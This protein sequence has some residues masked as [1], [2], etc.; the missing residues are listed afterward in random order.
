[1]GNEQKKAIETLSRQMRRWIVE[2]TTKAQSGHLTSSLS[3]VELMSVLF[4]SQEKLFRYDVKNVEHPGNDRLIFSKGHASP[5]FY[6]LWAMAGVID[7]KELMTFRSFESR[8]EGHPTRRFPYTEVPT[9]S[10]GQGI[11]VALGEALALREQSTESGKWKTEKKIHLDSENDVLA[12]GSH[13]PHVFVLLG[14]SEIAEGSV[15][16]SVAIASHYKLNNLVAIV[17]VN[18]LGQR[19]ETMDGWDISSIASKFRAFGWEAIE[20]E[21]GHSVEVIE[22]AYKRALRSEKPYVLVAKTVKGKGISLLENENGWHGKTLS[23]EEATIALKEIGVVKDFSL[24]ALAPP[25]KNEIFQDFKASSPQFQALRLFTWGV[26]GY[27]KSVWK[28]FIGN[29]S[30]V[31]RIGSSRC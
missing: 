5:L 12:D 15:W 6:S 30:G 16:E 27:A 21:D 2:M 10:L 19:G 3:A 24:G 8:L 17:D 28:S 18:R 22:D 1:M 11:G 20:I 26:C 9:G 31:P 4:F 14:D 13:S 25:L 29:R 23:Q 7:E